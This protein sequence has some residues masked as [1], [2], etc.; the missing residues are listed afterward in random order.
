MATTFALFM[1]AV[2]IAHSV[3]VLWTSR[4]SARADEIEDVADFV[5]M[6][7]ASADHVG[8]GLPDHSRANVQP[9]GPVVNGQLPSDLQQFLEKLV[10]V[11]SAADPQTLVTMMWDDSLVVDEDQ[12]LHSVFDQ[13]QGNHG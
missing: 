12:E 6:V 2:V 3:I 1:R 10:S 4:L 8:L 7:L 13:Y 5:Q 9:Y 11:S